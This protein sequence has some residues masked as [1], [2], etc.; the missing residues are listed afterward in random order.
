MA[1]IIS[2]CAHIGALNFG[3]EIHLYVMQNEF[4]LDVYLGSA[5]VDMYAKYRCLDISLLVFLKLREKNLF[6]WN[7][8]IEGLVVHG[9]AKEALAMFS[10][11]EGEKI[12]PNGVTF[13]SVLN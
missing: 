5:L 3:K 10:R 7:S 1:I 4:D 6:C 2:A 13:I 12:K 11:M 9:Y 8:I